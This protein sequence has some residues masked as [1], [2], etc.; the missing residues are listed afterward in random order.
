MKITINNLLI[1]FPVLSVMSMSCSDMMIEEPN[2]N[3]NFTCAD[4][5]R[6]IVYK[7]IFIRNTDTLYFSAATSDENVILKADEELDKP[8]D[9]RIKHINGLLS[10]GECDYNPNYDWHFIHNE[11]DLVEASIEWCDAFP[12]NPDSTGLDRVCPW[13]SR[14]YERL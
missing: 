7:F 4:S 3:N 8:L 5:D 10:P 11:W 2:H 9:N 1:I 6:L 12:A 13:S 14:V